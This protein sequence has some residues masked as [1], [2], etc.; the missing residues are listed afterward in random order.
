MQSQVLLGDQAS[1]DTC[2]QMGIQ[3]S[4]H[5]LWT[6][7]LL[8]FEE[9]PREDGN[10]VGMC[11]DKVGERVTEAILLLESCDLPLLIGQ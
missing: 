10:S 7:I 8:T 4:C 2:A 1:A 6:D 9:S 3:E 11:L 5:V